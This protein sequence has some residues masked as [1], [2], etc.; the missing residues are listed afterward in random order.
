MILAEMG[1]FVGTKI[2]AAIIFLAI[3]AG[4]Y[5]CYKHPEAVKAFGHVVKLTLLWIVVAAA[6]PWSS[7]LFMRPLLGFQS[8]RLSTNGAA[9]LSIAVIAAY[10]VI[11]IVF[12]FF[13]G[14]FIGSGTLTWIVLLLGFLAAGAY[15]YVICESL[16]RHVES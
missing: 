11:D 7:Y 13:L 4:G 1:K 8:S 12:A 9:A 15:N 10:C 6:L 16:A 2:A 5:W 3:A 14:D